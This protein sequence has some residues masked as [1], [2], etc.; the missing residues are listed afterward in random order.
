MKPWNFETMEHYYYKKIRFEKYF[1]GMENCT[2]PVVLE[3]DHFHTKA[4]K[5]LVP[6]CDVA[7]KT[8]NK[9]I[10]FASPAAFMLVFIPVCRLCRC[11]GVQHEKVWYD[12]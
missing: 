5:S 2:K 11:I 3:V 9:P 1:G 7:R 4:P 8:T 10:N 6:D 12:S